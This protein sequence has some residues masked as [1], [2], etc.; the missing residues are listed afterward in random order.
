[1]ASNER[2]HNYK[3]SRSVTVKIIIHRL[4]LAIWMDELM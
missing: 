3:S 4:S 1:M 2:H